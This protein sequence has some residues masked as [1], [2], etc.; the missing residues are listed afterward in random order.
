M[1]TIS[2]NIF[3]FAYIIRINKTVAIEKLGEY[4]RAGNNMTATFKYSY[5]KK[6]E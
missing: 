4:L 6:N 3:A 2:S 5:G 1:L